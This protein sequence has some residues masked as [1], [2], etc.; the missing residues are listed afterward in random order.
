M[1]SIFNK[2]GYTIN[3]EQLTSSDIKIVLFT[4]SNQDGT[5]R[6]IWNETEK[7]PLFLKFY[8]V[9]SFRASLFEMAIKMIFLFNLQNFIFKK[10]TYFISEINNPVFDFTK[11]WA[12]FMG[13]VGPNNKAILYA[14]K[15][16]YKIATT[17]NSRKLIA[18]EF[19]VL[20]DLKNKMDTFIIPKATQISEEIIQL[21]DVSKNGIRTKKINSSH[22]LTLLEMSAFTNEK[23]IASQFGLHQEMLNEVSNFNDER[24]PKNMVRKFQQIVSN[25]NPK[26]ELELNLSQGDFTQWNTY[27]RNGKL[28]IYDWELAGFDKTKGF[29][30]FHYIIQKG[31]LIDRKSWKSIYKDIE[32]QYDSRFGK[33]FFEDEKDFKKCL[34]WYLLSNCFQYLKVYSAQKVW[35]EQI[36]W[37]LQTWS[38]ALNMFLLEEK[39][40][41]QLL[42]M[43]LFDFLQDKKYAT[44]KMKNGFPENLS[45]FSDIDMII[46]KAHANE[47]VKFINNHSLV[48]KKS[49]LKKSFMNAIKIVTTDSSILSLDLIWEVKRKNLVML[50]AKEIIANQI[51]SL[52]GVNQASAIDTYRYIVLFYILNGAKIPSKHAELKEIVDTSSEPLDL[53]IKEYLVDNK[54][55]SKLVNYVKSQKVNKSLSYIKNSISYL[56]DTV[57]ELFNNRGF[58]ITFSGVDGAGKSTVIEHVAHKIEKQL[59]KPVVLL[60]HRPSILPIL[61]VWT[62]GKEKAHQDTISSLPRQ[63]KNGSFISSLIRFSY[64]YI[65]YL[66]GQF[67]IYFKYILRGK[68][69]IYDRYYFDFINDSKRSNIQLSKKITSF[70]YNLLM[71]PKFNFFLFADANTILNRKKELSKATIEKLTNDYLELFENLKKK[72]NSSNYNAIENKDLDK[73]LNQIVSTVIIES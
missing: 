57:N 7:K 67:Y 17:P 43:D 23:L 62:K 41:R 32:K 22:K 47:V 55:N 68:V 61:S 8:N 72:S 49:Q 35:H 50:N 20:K 15:S 9:G 4:I 73:T 29:D 27:E 44:L 48:A 33:A 21:S 11:H 36:N 5:P 40:E 10:Q 66:I 18:N 70:G 53:L 45:L 28:A 63:G 58:T 14:N 16:F 1:K 42:I 6:W 19:Q 65:D 26:E 69:V 37:L 30:F 56:M 3:N 46:D 13:T 2:L 25:I 31:I 24:L 64:Y 12:L 60:R 38:D 71:K 54:G 39:T 34:K 52:Y 59:R 51:T